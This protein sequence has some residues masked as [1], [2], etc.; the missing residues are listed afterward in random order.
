MRN[1]ELSRRELLASLGIGA[2]CL[3]LL[4][5]TR[6]YAAAP[7][8]PKRFICVL[9]TEGYR[10]QYWLPMGGP[11]ANQTL[12]P[13]TT[14]LDGFKNDIIILGNLTNPKYPGC[15]RWGHGTYGS[16]FSGGPVDMASGNGKEYWEP[17]IPTVDQVV[18]TGIAKTAPQ[19]VRTTLP[20]EV[21]VGSGGYLGSKRCFWAGPKQPVTP[22]SN[23][24]KIYSE[25]FAGATTSTGPDPAVQ[26]LIAERRSLL[27]FVGKDLEK[28]GARLGTEDRLSIQGH[29]QSI[30]DLEKQLTM[31]RMPIGQCGVVF[32]GDPAKPIDIAANA[33]VPVVLN[34]QQQLIVAALKCDVT[35]VGTLQFGDA[36][37]GAIVFDFVPGVPTEGNGYQAL[38]NWHDL[39]HRPVRPDGTDDKKTVDTWCMARF[40]DMLTMLRNIPEGLNETMLDHTCVLWANHMEAGDTH[41]AQKLPWILAGKCGGYFKTGQCIP[42][43]GKPMMGILAEICNA[44]DV[45]V[46][47]FGDPDLGKPMTELR[48]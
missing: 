41:G 31:Q 26:R 7:A 30:V 27:D 36:T 39:G 40:A 46:D 5:V 34:L 9:L 21:K 12:P 33:N 45:P 18:A 44:M 4:H 35:R 32:S 28:F 16:I 22:E 19:L 25:I 14:P 10:M 13:S 8:F 43:P 29:L 48:A 47:H 24:Y 1:W 15:D 42:N 20:L 11:L 23:P 38:R 6:T 37:G 17:T 3:P 2:A